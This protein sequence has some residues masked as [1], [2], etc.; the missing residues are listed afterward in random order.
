[1][2]LWCTRTVGLFF[3]N[4]VWPVPA[5]FLGL[6]RKVSV[7]KNGQRSVT[8]LSSHYLSPQ[9]CCGHIA[10]S[11]AHSCAVLAAQTATSL[12]QSRGSGNRHAQDQ[13]CKTSWCGMTCWPEGRSV[14]HGIPWTSTRFTER[15]NHLSQGQAAGQT[16]PGERQL[17]CD[18]H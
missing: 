17:P 16:P 2:S 10:G 5:V 15:Q 13:G 12:T 18:F 4:T 3:L 7:Y 1:M 14:L 6:I 11:Q 8:S 9:S